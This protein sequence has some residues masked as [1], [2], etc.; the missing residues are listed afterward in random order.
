MNPYSVQIPLYQ[1]SVGNNIDLHKDPHPGA[2]HI[3]AAS[4]NRRY[5]YS[6]TTC[7]KKQYSVGTL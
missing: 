5:T 4:S 7:K 1:L 3:S 2:V 6:A